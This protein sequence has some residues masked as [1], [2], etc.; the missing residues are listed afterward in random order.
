VKHIFLACRRLLARPWIP[1]SEGKTPYIWLFSLLILGWKY[2]YV[3][4]FPHEFP[5]L[6]VSLLG[7]FVVYFHSYWVSNWR[8][9]PHIIFC[10][11]LGILWAPYN[12][13]TSTLVIFSSAMC[14]RME[15]P[16]MAYGTLITMMVILAVL[17][18]KLLTARLDSYFWL[19]AMI[20]GLST[21]IGSIIEQQLK[22]S[23]D[24]L[25]RSQEEVEHLAALA[26]RERIS[27]DMHDILG[28][29]LSVI[30]LK[31]E[32]AGKLLGRDREACEK[33]IK[34]IEN[35]ARRALGEV[36]S[37]V[38]G[39]RA[40]GLAHELQAA[41]NA[42]RAAQVSLE[43]DVHNCAFPAAAENVMALTL[44]EAVT[45]IIRHAQASHCK[46]GL[47]L[48]ENHARLCISDNGALLTDVG[49][50]R[51]GNG[52]RGMC[53]RAHALG[54]DLKMFCRQGLVLELSLPLGTTA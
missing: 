6:A 16:R 44:R 45:N 12:F 8:I 49:N 48:E 24:K 40:T 2:F 38:T 7:F 25:L 9:L 35:T 11:L 18:L 36:R 42:L 5:L 28:H 54:G 41:Q 23:R 47:R 31:A 53:E 52:L 13:G 21:G 26:E 51:M 20:F 17:S 43:L 29:S 19:P 37:A 27:R 4:S 34:D 1:P 50:V 39:Y 3:P 15:K 46:I 30:T 14:G 33:E 10:F 22:R 32:L